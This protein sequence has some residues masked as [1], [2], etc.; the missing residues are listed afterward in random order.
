MRAAKQKNVN[1]YKIEVQLLKN[2][3][4]QEAIAGPIHRKP[5]GGT[6]S[7]VDILP[8]RESHSEAIPIR[9]LAG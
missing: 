3:A 7:I 1:D 6:Q 9:S 4:D 5:L 8:L 2:N